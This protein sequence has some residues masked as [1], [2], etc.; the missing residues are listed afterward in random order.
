M[1]FA[2]QAQIKIGQA[3]LGFGNFRPDQK[4]FSPLTM[5]SFLS[6]KGDGNKK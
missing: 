1:A 4:P 2:S 3:V 6:Q 5:P